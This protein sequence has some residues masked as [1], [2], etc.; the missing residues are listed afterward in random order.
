M[1]D[2]HFEDQWTKTASCEDFLMAEDGLGEDRLIM[3]VTEVNIKLL[4]EAQTIY[5]DGTFQT[6][7]RLGIGGS[8]LLQFWK[9]LQR[10]AAVTSPTPLVHLVLAHSRCTYDLHG[11]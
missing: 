7:P 4:C 3:F 8:P 11:L 2:V 6:C 5:V 10:T 1:T 9:P